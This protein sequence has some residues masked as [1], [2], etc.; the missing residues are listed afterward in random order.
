MSNSAILF[1]G[2]GRRHP[3]IKD[4]NLFPLSIQSLGSCLGKQISKL[5]TS[6]VQSIIRYSDVPCSQNLRVHVSKGTCSHG[7]PEETPIRVL[8]I[9]AS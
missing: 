2:L 6:L 9:F 4:A 7:Q 1:A 5:L 8:L 3:F